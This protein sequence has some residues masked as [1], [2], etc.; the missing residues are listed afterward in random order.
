MPHYVSL[1]KFT[2][3]GAKNMQESPKRMERIKEMFKSAGAE[4]KSMYAVLGEYDSVMI[5]EAPNDETMAKL[6]LMVASEGNVHCETLRAFNEQEFK[7]LLMGMAELKKA[8]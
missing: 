3:Q 7:Q 4:V 2:E 1:Y 6:N 8:A 5:A